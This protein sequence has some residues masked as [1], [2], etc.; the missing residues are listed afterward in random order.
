M[1]ATTPTIHDAF[2]AAVEATCEAQ[3]NAIRI[4]SELVAELI[5]EYLPGATTITVDGT[6][7]A[8]VAINETDIQAWQASAAGT[9]LSDS[10]LAQTQRTVRRML[11]I[12][13]DSVILADAGWLGCTDGRYVIEL[14]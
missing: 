10:L 11:R 3:A 14:G 8:L 9:L 1:T 13:S 5:W 6:T 7:G 12:S 2:A 4:G